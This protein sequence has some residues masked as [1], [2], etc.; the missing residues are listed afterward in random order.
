[1]LARRSALAVY[2]PAALLHE[3]RHGHRTSQPAAH[4]RSA[5][6]HDPIFSTTVKYNYQSLL[7]FLLYPLCVFHL[8]LSP[9]THP[10]RPPPPL[11]HFSS[12][13]TLKSTTSNL[14]VSPLSHHDTHAH[15]H[16]HTQTH[17]EAFRPQELPWCIMT[18]NWPLWVCPRQR[19]PITV[20]ATSP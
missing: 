12:F 8:Q 18:D 14:P 10:P 20:T 9:F 19:E 4:W 13:S 3:A 11:L 5:A 6:P 16:M 15:T 2:A 17:A 7:C 1:M